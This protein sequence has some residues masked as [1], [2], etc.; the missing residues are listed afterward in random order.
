MLV[1]LQRIKIFFYNVVM[2]FVLLLSVLFIVGDFRGDSDSILN[3][4]FVYYL[5]K[6]FFI[7]TIPLY[8]W[9]IYWFTLKFIKNDVFISIDDEYL[10]DQS[11]YIALGK[12]KLTDIEMVYSKD[13]FIC[14]KLKNPEEYLKNIKGIKKKLILANKKMKY[15]YICISKTILGNNNLKFYNMLQEKIKN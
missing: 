6:I 8:I 11:S 9:C 13:V 1:R 3:N 15:E 4:V 5:F 12:I 10:I 7:I 2:V 14:V